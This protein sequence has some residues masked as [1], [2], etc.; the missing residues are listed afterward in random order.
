MK[1]WFFQQKSYKKI[2]TRL[3]DEAGTGRGSISR[4][5]E[6]IG[7]QRSYL[8]QVLHSKVQLTKE[9]AWSACAFFGLSREETAYFECLVDHERA[10][11]AVYKRHLE[12]RMEEIRQ[13]AAHI[14]S[15]T[16]KSGNANEHEAL[17][18]F[19]HWLPCAV[20]LLTSVPEFQETTSMAARLG[21]PLPLVRQTL[22]ELQGMG[23]VKQEKTRWVFAGSSKWMPRESPL[24]SFHHQNWRQ[25]AFENSRLPRAGGIHYTMVQTVSKADLEKLRKMVREFM[26]QTNKV[27]EPS[28]PEVLTTL[29][30]DFFE[31]R[32]QA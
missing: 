15:K 22:S 8:S 7:C 10:A 14:T 27:A 32:I 6:A 21:V 26:D 16:Q 4:V 12:N 17:Y 2:L 29:N 5:A 20:H 11:S 25:L 23:L 1:I 3:I 31:P 28:S 18:Y 24:V 13:D 30:I 9:Q 19:S